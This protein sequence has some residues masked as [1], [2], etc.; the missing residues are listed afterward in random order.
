MDVIPEENEVQDLNSRGIIHFSDYLISPQELTITNMLRD[1]HF[2]Y[3]GFVKFDSPSQLILAMPKHTSGSLLSSARSFLYGRSTVKMKTARGQ[4]VVTAV[5]LISA[6]GD[7]IDF[8]FIGGELHNT[9]SNYYHQGKLNHTRMQKFMLTSDSFENTH[10]YEID[11]DEDRILWIVDGEVKRTLYKKDTWNDEEQKYEYPETPM[12]LQVSV[13]PAGNADADPGTIM[14][15][16]GLIDW[17]NSPDITEK[18]QY[19]AVVESV[20]ITPYQNQ[21]WPSIVAELEKSHLPIDASSM[22]DI[23]YNYNYTKT[24]SPTSFENS[25]IW[26]KGKVPYLTYTS[27]DGLNPGQFGTRNPLNKKN[28]I[29]RFAERKKKLS[30]SHKFVQDTSK[31]TSEDEESLSHENTSGNNHNIATNTGFSD[32]HRN[33]FRKLLIFFRQ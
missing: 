2:T 5:V 6:V 28:E 3:S 10:I 32:H 20:A 25:V 16:G 14:W 12:R 24:N 8:E 30:T 21:F 9:Q 29:E 31:S 27:N 17:E 23:T 13:W 22:E 7:E 4:G 26:I 19:Y 1:Y 33:P 11:W 15:A 18:G